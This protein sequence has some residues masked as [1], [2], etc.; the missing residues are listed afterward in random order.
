MQ[1]TTLFQKIYRK[2]FI[3]IL[4]LFFLITVFVFLNYTFLTITVSGENTDNAAIQIKDE[5]GKYKKLRKGSNFVK[6]GKYLLQAETGSEKT[7]K[8]ITL[9]KLGTLQV[10]IELKPQIEVKKILSGSLGCVSGISRQDQTI[11]T[12]NCAGGANNIL[13]Y[14][15]N[16]KPS[17]IPT[18]MPRVYYPKAYKNG[19][20]GFIASGL[21]DQ[22]Q[23][24]YVEDGVTK[25]LPY[26][27]PA[28]SEFGSLDILPLEDTS[29]VVLN[30][31]DFEMAFFNNIDAEKPEVTQL[32]TNKTVHQGSSVGSEV[33]ILS[34]NLIDTNDPHA[35]EI[36]DVSLTS[37]RINKDGLEAG[38]NLAVENG[39]KLFGIKVMQ[40]GVYVIENLEG[41]IDI[42]SGDGKNVE[43]TDSI[44]GQLATS[45]G[46]GFAYLE[47]S[48]FYY[49]DAAS[50]SSHLLYS[51]GNLFRANSVESV[52]E[53]L[54]FHLIGPG[55][56]LFGFT[57]TVNPEYD[58]SLIK[59]LE[60]QNK[61]YIDTIDFNQ[62][63]IYAKLLLTS[64][65][66]DHETGQFTFDPDEFNAKKDQFNKD[67]S[68]MGI[69]LS[70]YRI[71]V[72]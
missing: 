61:N 64:Y 22:L 47:G 48:D 52:D 30:K 26:F 68:G 14:K 41:T 71:V 20:L 24:A 46:D 44:T 7:K 40:Q 38:N 36:T 1:D 32:D 53:V 18:N 51:P 21:D 34:A 39:T 57:T 42:Y 62:N 6:R 10:N 13:G 27:I 23:L 55:G 33:F 25:Q 12:Y 16:D 56:K 43:Q 5:D 3:I 72:D 15:F 49:Y 28:E 2:R 59:I 54:V 35:E 11:Y 17:L 60:L 65:V 70:K 19:L 4:A 29:F 31:N 45:Y 58:T 50:S 63:T 37:Y 8:N 69:D 66:S 9:P 67:L